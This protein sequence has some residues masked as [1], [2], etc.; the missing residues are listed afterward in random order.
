[1]MPLSPNRK[2]TLMDALLFLLGAAVLIALV[3][4]LASLAG[5]DTRDGFDPATIP[6]SNGGSPLA[7]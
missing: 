1:M 6:G 7:L 3:G 2:E 4:A 5:A